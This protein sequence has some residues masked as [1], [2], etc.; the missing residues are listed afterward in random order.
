MSSCAC[1]HD[2]LGNVPAPT[3]FCR[4]KGLRS[5]Y[6]EAVVDFWV[7]APDDVNKHDTNYVSVN[8]HL[9]ARHEWQSCRECKLPLT[10]FSQRIFATSEAFL[11]TAASASK[12][13]VPHSLLRYSSITSAATPPGLLFYVTSMPRCDSGSSLYISSR[14]F[15]S[16]V[17]LFVV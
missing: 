15:L 7:L 9:R 16:F 8:A 5:H 1:P 4:I 17:K 13:H 12:V 11:F 2:C 6:I 3:A 14:P 10:F